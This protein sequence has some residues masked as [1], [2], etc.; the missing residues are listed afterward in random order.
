MTAIQTLGRDDYEYY[1]SGFRSWLTDAGDKQ[2]AKKVGE[3]LEKA[4]AAVQ[5]RAPAKAKRTAKKAKV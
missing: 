2:Y 3:V 5:G 4:V 1:S